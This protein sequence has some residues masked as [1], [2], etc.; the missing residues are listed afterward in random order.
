MPDTIA[1]NVSRETLIA[2]DRTALP[3]HEIDV[4]A[5]SVRAWAV[6]ACTAEVEH[7]E[8][9]TRL[10]ALRHGLPHDDYLHPD[11]HGRFR[12]PHEA[13][14]GTALVWLLHLQTEER[15]IAETRLQTREP[16]SAEYMAKLEARRAKLQTGFDH[17]VED[18]RE[19]RRALDQ[20]RAA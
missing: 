9:E 6:A 4:A 3:S 10:L 5:D 19:G 11:W 20:R 13:K 18:Y 16:A 8:R 1:P 7:A 17:A 2:A 14:A 15:L 12:L